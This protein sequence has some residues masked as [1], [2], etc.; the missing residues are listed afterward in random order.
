MSTNNYPDDLPDLAALEK[1]A[2]QFFSALP[3][4]FPEGLNTQQFAQQSFNPDSVQRY[5]NLDFGN[6]PVDL[7]GAGSLGMRSV[8]SSLAGSGISPSALNVLSGVDVPHVHPVFPSP[9]SIGFGKVPPSMGGIGF[10]PSVVP[11][12]NVIDLRNPQPNL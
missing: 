12:A 5:E 9:Q 11:S 2:N 10:S 6:I 1:L 8:S 7:P 3:G 4:T